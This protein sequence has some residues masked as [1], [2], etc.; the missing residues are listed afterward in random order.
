M[1]L[2]DVARVGFQGRAKRSRQA[3]V[4][5]H[6]AQFLGCLWMGGEGRDGGRGRKG[7]REGKEGM[8]GGEGRIEGGEGREE[9]FAY[10]IH[11]F[12]VSSNDFCDAFY[13]SQS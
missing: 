2:A 12:C 13:K 4:L 10:L 6:L 9:F 3:K 7:W 5:V 1:Q 11:F 8:E